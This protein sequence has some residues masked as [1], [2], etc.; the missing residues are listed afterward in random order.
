MS[1][2]EPE[3]GTRREPTTGGEGPTGDPDGTHADNNAQQRQ[4]QVWSVGAVSDVGR[5]EDVER[6]AGGRGE[7]ARDLRVPVNLLHVALALRNKRGTHQYLH[8]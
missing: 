3:G 5:L 8:S 4:P 6:V 1:R 2:S 7:D